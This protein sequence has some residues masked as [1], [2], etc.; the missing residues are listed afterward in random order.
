ML[1]KHLNESNLEFFNRVANNDFEMDIERNS[2][3]SIKLSF[4]LD[5]P[6]NPHTKGE[7]QTFP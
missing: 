2:W 3:G 5:V 6:I 1:E 7:G 4:N